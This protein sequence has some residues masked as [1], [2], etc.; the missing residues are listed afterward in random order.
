[1]KQTGIGRGIQLLGG[2]FLIVGTVDLIV[3]ALFPAYALKLFWTAVAGPASFLVKLHTPAV[4]LLIG[5]G[6]LWLRPWAWGLALA[7]AGFGL[8][9]DGMNQLT[10]GFNYIQSGFMVT[11]SFFSSYLI[12]RRAVFI[13]EPMS[14]NRPK[15]APQELR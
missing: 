7:Y 15:P 4:H 10:F 9:S 1:M 13:D 2:L 14:G 6:S 11:T 3:I 8:V 12:W 5:Y